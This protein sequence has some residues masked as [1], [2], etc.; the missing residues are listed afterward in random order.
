LD[1]TD[2]GHGKLLRDVQPVAVLPVVSKDTACAILH[3][4]EQALLLAREGGQ[5]QDGS[6]PGG[7]RHGDFT[8]LD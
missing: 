1:N 7:K 8:D 3:L 6:H 4:L 2:Y 5:R